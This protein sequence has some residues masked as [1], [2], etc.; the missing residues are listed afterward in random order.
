MISNAGSAGSTTL[1]R[2]P[3]RGL[4]QVHVVLLGLA[5]LTIFRLWYS[6]R[7]GLAPDEAYYWLWSKHLAASYRD[8]GPAIAWAIALSRTFFGDTVFGVRVLGVLLATG[9]AWEIYRLAR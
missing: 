7:L 2:V 8:K 4:R 1:D 3:A 6:T 9:T 5:A